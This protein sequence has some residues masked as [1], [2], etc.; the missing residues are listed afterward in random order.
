M[1]TD[2]LIFGFILFYLLTQ[3][4]AVCI[5]HDYVEM[6]VVGYEAALELYYEGMFL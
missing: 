6:G 4:T 2:D 5:T 3:V 1:L